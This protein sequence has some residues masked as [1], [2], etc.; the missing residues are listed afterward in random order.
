[1]V[2][3]QQ[4]GTLV[5]ASGQC[6]GEGGCHV[7]QAAGLG[8]PHDFGGG[9][10]DFQAFEPF[11]MFSHNFGGELAVDGLW[12]LLSRAMSFFLSVFRTFGN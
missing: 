6:S 8:K 11:R 10:H 9:M 1:M 7:R 12:A 4:D 5:A 2:E 3:R